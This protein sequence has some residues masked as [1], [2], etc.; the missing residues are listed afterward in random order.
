M[1]LTRLERLSPDLRRLGI[2]LH[3]KVLAARCASAWAL[4]GLT[5]AFP[6]R[7]AD[8]NGNR[9]AISEPWVA[10]TAPG[11]T[12]AAGFM[13][14]TNSGTEIDRLVAVSSPVA[15]AVELHM[16]RVDAAG[17]ARMSVVGPV[18]LP[19]GRTISFDPHGLALM[20]V[21]I[22]R[23]LKAGDSVPVTLSFERSGIIVLA[24]PVQKLGFAGHHHAGVH[25]EIPLARQ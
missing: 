10:A 13:T 25:D 4:I 20:L 16:H 1:K 17:I 5:L 9:I 15:R 11:Q 18:D 19:A 7:A 21:D 22:A 2:Q 24:M 6:G 8:P 3:R 12:V 14:V 23:P